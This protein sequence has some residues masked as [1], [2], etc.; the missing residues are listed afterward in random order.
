MIL[1]RKLDAGGQPVWPSDVVVMEGQA[2]PAH[3]NPVL[4]PDGT[5]GVFVG[6]VSISQ[7]VLLWSTFQHLDASGRLTMP[8]DGVRVS[9]STSTMQVDPAPAYVSG[10]RELVVAWSERNATQT[11]RGLRAQRLTAEGARLWGDQG[12]ELVPLSSDGPSIAGLRATTNG[13]LLVYGEP[14]SASGT[15]LRVM[16]AQLPLTATPAWSP[17]A[18]SGDGPTQGPF[19]SGRPECGTWVVYRDGA[20][21]SGDIRGAF[22]AAP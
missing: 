8:A 2:V 16:G 10:A 1:A 22:F 18:L 9:L 11:S 6:W 13:A 20:R 5:G 17:T 15:G 14:T 7:G 21:D 12:I 19:L 3:V 4:E